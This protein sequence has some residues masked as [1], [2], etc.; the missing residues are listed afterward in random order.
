MPFPNTEDLS[1]LINITD[2]FVSYMLGFLWADGHVNKRNFQVFLKIVS[3]DFDEIKDRWLATAQS[4][5][6]QILDRSHEGRQ[7]QALVSIYHKIFHAFLVQCGY[8]FKSGDSA[9]DILGVIPKNLR[10]YWWRGY[11][12]GD[13]C[14][15][16][17]R[18]RFQL[19]ISGCYDQD[20]TFFDKLA[21]ELN[22]TYGIDRRCNEKRG[23]SAISIGNEASIRRFMEYIYQ[24]ESFGLSRKRNN[25]REFL[26]YKEKIRL[27]KTSRY[28]GVHINDRRNDYIMRIVKN[29]RLICKY[30]KTEI[31]A[32][33]A[34]DKIA[35]ELYGKIAVLNFPDNILV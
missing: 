34:Y 14:F 35:V 3:K 11:F 22:V 9:D 20:W 26:A 24:G 8:I 15:S 31:E 2:P 1:S 18:S 19:G 16:V 17:S 4:W 5:K 32:A 13:G 7:S 27:S 6:Y 12:D 28:R 29:K 21:I 10:H 25:Y 23:V 33:R 30:F